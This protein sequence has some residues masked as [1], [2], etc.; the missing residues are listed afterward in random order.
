L[1]RTSP[2]QSEENRLEENFPYTIRR[3]QALERTSPTQSEENRLAE[4][5]SYTIRREQ[6]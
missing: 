2:T 3:E 6:A 1:K 4:N 5:F